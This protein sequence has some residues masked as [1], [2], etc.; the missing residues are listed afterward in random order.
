MIK[1]FA[2]WSVLAGIFA[3]CLGFIWVDHGLGDPL[4]RDDRWQLTVTL[5]VLSLV[6]FFSRGL[7]WFGV[8]KVAATDFVARAQSKVARSVARPDRSVLKALNRD[9]RERHGRF[10]RRKTRV[11]LVVGEPD[12]IEAIAPCL[13]EER[14]LAG[15]NTVLLWGGSLRQAPDPADLALWRSLTR[16]RGFDGV[17]WALTRE[18]SL[19]D[20]AMCAAQQGLRGLARDLYWH[21]PLYVWQVCHSKW[22]QQGRESHGVGCLLPA[23]ATAA[24]LRDELTELVDPLR[25]TGLVQLQQDRRHDFFLRLSSELRHEGIQRWSHVLGPWFGGAVRGVTLR[26]LW[27]SLPFLSYR[28]FNLGHEWLADKAWLGVIEDRTHPR[29]LGWQTPRIVPV[30]LLLLALIWGAGMALSFTSNRAQIAE[31]QTTL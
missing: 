9:L 29:R 12:E 31:M 27:F 4:S 3:L 11:L 5:L 17:V 10:W 24:L 15:V 18:Q 2:V 19:D 1:H 20:G 28:R 16:W 14:W 13:G 6:L 22:S 7:G 26:G 8:R 23:K 25:V 21:L 30:G